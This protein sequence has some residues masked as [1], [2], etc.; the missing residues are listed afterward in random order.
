M[1]RLSDQIQTGGR[2]VVFFSFPANVSC[3]NHLLFILLIELRGVTFFQHVFRLEGYAVTCCHHVLMVEIVG[4]P[5]FACSRIQGLIQKNGLLKTWTP[6]V[7][8]Q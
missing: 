6:P 2:G 4:L 1:I 3:A 5:W 8:K 7:L